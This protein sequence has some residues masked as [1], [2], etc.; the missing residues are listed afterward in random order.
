MA[1]AFIFDMDGVIINSETVWEKYEEIFLSGLLGKN[2][3]EKIKGDLLGS[4]AKVIYG[5]AK[6]NGLVMKKDDFFKTYDRQ[7]VSVYKESVLTK[8]IETLIEKLVSLE[9]NIGLVTSSRSLW[10]DQVIPRL[11]N[12]DS[13]KYIL[14]I[15][16]RDDL[17]SKPSPAGYIEA[18]KKLNSSPAKTIILEDSNKGIQSAKQSGALTI[19]LREHILEGHT[20]QGAD[21]Y[22]D[23]LASLIKLL[24]VTK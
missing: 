20:P 6:Q 21:I 11:K 5:I 2:I 17:E 9:F 1:K 3:Y 23:D 7:A 13:F 10:I 19:C 16:D 18:M 4:T 24:E 22:I 15:G 12:R 14:S 8:D